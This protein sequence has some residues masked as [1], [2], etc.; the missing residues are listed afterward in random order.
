MTPAGTPLMLYPFR[1]L[2]KLGINLCKWRVRMST[3]M[4]HVICLKLN[5]AQYNKFPLK[6]IGFGWL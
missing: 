2:Q 1:I 6:K 4:E 3:S 5:I